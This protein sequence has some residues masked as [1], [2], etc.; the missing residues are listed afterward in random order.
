MEDRIEQAAAGG[1]GG[2]ETRLQ[3]VAQGHQFIDF[4]DDAV[5]FSEG[6]EGHKHAAKRLT[7]D[8]GLTG[9]P[10]TVLQLSPIHWGF[11]K[12]L[13]IPVIYFMR[14]LYSDQIGSEDRND[15]EVGGL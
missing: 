14:T 4:G 10:R 13:Q 5:L 3:P 11:Q 2:I 8:I 7:I 12:E 9:S 6:W 15:R 1:G